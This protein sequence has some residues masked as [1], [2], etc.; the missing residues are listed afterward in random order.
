MEK[1]TQID[2]IL[3]DK[4]HIPSVSI[5]SGDQTAILTTVWW[6]QKLEKDLQH[7]TKFDM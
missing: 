7:N 4:R 2:H 5:F 1:H 6:W 3:V